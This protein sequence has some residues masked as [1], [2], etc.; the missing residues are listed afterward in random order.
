M[1]PGQRI[2]RGAVETPVRPGLPEVQLEG[3]DDGLHVGV[4]S[5]FRIDFVAVGGEQGARPHNV[6]T[7]RAEREPRI[8]LVDW[9]WCNPMAH[10]VLGKPCPAEFLAR[11]DLAPRRDIGMREHVAGVHPVA[12]DDLSGKRQHRPHLR[13][14]EVPIAEHVA[15]VL[16][17]DPDGGRI[18]VRFAPPVGD[19]RV[20]CAGLFGDHLDDAPVLVD[21]VMARHLAVG[22]R[23]NVERAVDGRQPR[24]MQD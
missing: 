19:A 6:R 4:E 9:S 23:E 17:L 18:D 12:P 3:F 21:D 22:P 13:R 7:A 20:P 11:I 15:W 10:A 1:E 14:G 24:V 5:T 8:A 16:D 2:E